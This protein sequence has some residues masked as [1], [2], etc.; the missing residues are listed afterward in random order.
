MKI[1]IIRHGE[2]AWMPERKY[3]GISDIPLSET[4]KNKLEKAGYSPK[5]VYVSPLIRAKETAFCIFPEAEQQVIPGLSEMDFGVFEGRSADDMADD[6]DYRTWVDGMCRGR[7]PGGESTDEF[8]DRVCAAFEDLVNE[9]ISDEKETACPSD[10]PVRIIVAHGGTAMAVME[11]FSEEKRTFYEWYLK[12]GC[13]YILDTA[14]WKEK[15][16]LKF[17]TVSNHNKAS[18]R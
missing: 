9:W 17:L 2:T 11:R 4:G 10:D 16:Q 13:G 14:P 6:P 15:K 1:E 3:Q 5:T 12:S 8:C 18:E 7:C